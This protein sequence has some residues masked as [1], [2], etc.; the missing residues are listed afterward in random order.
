MV[1]ALEVDFFFHLHNYCNNKCVL[2]DFKLD[3]ITVIVLDICRKSYI[4]IR[5][6]QFLKKYLK[7]DSIFFSVFFLSLTTYENENIQI[8]ALLIVVRF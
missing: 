6:I 7:F 4:K 2:L 1:S 3:T 8:Y 5:P